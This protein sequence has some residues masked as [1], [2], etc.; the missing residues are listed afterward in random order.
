MEAQSFIISNINAISKTRTL[1]FIY[2]FYKFYDLDLLDKKTAKKK[3]MIFN[4]I[5]LFSI[6]S[7][8]GKWLFIGSL[9]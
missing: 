3:K 9:V 4:S 1:N 5:V 7:T 8:V 2:F 6:L